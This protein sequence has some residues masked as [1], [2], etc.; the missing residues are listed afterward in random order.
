MHNRFEANYSS[1]FS[2]YLADMK[3]TLHL[4]KQA[5]IDKER[6]ILD[7]GVGFQKSFEQN[8]EV[9]HKTD[10]LCELGY[11][12]MLAVSRKSVIGNALDKTVDQRLYGTLATTVVGVMKG[13]SF[14]RVHDVEENCDVIRMTKSILEEKKWIK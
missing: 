13:A 14:I 10:A 6:I 1:F 2:D 5:G 8:L 4:A 12:V 11:P 9:I 7:G 3:E